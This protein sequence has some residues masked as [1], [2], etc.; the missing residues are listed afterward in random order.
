MARHSVEDVVGLQL[1][2]ETVCRGC[3]TEQEWAQ[4]SEDEILMPCEEELAFCDR[5]KERIY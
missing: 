3:V 5:C 4:V 2:E 1:Y